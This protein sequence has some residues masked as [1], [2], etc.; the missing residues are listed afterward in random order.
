MKSNYVRLIKLELYKTIMNFFKGIFKYVLVCLLL[1]INQRDNFINNEVEN[2]VEEEFADDTIHEIKNTI[3]KTEIKNALSQSGGEVYRFNIK[4]YAFVYDKI[5]F[6]P[7]SDIE[8]NTLTTDNFFIHVNRLIKGKVHLH[9]SRTAGKILGYSHDFCNT[10]V[11][12]KTRS[13]ISFVAHNFFGFDIFYYLKTYI[14]SA[15]SSKKINIG[16]TNLTH[17]NYGII[18]NENKLIDS[19]KYY[20]KRLADLSST[21]TPEEK[22]AAEKVTKQIFNQYYYFSTVWPYLTL[23]LQEKVLDIVMS[24]RG[25]ISYE[26]IVD[27]QSLLLTPDDE[28]F[29]SKTQFVSELKLQAVNDESYENSKFLFKT[30]KMRN[31]GDFNDLYNTQDVIL[32]CEVLESRFQAM[33]STYGFNPRKCNSASTMSRCIEREMSKVI[34]TLPTKI[35]HVEIF[36]QTVIGGFSWV[37]NR[38]AFDTQ[39][40]LPNPVDS[41]MTVKKDFNYKIAYNLKTADNQKAKKRV[42]TKILKLDENN[43]Y[44]HGMTKSLPTG[45]IKDNSDLS[46]KSFSLLLES[47]SLEDRIGHLYIVDIE[48]DTK[49]ASEKI[50]AYNEIYPPIIEK[51]KLIDPCERSTYQLLEQFAM[52]EKG[53]SSYKKSAKAHANLFKKLFLPMY[54]EDLA[55]CIKRAGWKVTKIHAHL[56][57]EQSRFKRNFILMNQKLKQ[58]SKLLIMKKISLNS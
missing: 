23:K 51:H 1:N 31:L 17:V 10:S 47:V 39:L 7:C 2:F 19:L 12:E 41:E 50:L 37:N 11:I 42:I 9:H 29:C 32:L 48:F 53:P 14:A 18:D 8:Y 46:W 6:L 5:I 58:L 57:F 38:L 3:Q 22:R 15:W 24:G 13:E 52:G 30:L 54:L 36:E 34:I 28:Q 35:K 49:N 26:L 45:C 4:V 56:T 27:M 55:F 25:I 16:G 44:G 43:Q 20:Q 21:L 33:Q 40:L